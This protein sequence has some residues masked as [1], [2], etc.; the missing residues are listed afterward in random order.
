LTIQK[1]GIHEKK[2]KLGKK[3]VGRIDVNAVLCI[4]CSIQQK[5]E[6][7]KERE[8]YSSAHLPHKTF[9]NFK[10]KGNLSKY[11]AYS[12]FTPFS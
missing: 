6:K 2:F 3:M 10:E 7:V 11:F 8:I 9:N 4:A 5:R 12:S 1:V